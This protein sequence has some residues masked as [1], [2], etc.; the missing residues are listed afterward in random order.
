ML[1]VEPSGL[2]SP[3]ATGSGRNVSD[4]KKFTSSIKKTELCGYY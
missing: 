1:E 2:R 3:V 4:L